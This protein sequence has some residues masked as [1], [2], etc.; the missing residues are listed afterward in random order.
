VPQKR[1]KAAG[2][3]KKKGKKGD[4]KPKV[5]LLDEARPEGGEGKNRVHPGDGS[6]VKAHS[7]TNA[8]GRRREEESTSPIFV[9]LHRESANRTQR[10]KKKALPPDI[11]ISAV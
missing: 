6:H 5:L 8:G 2:G 1:R 9:P 10:K 7:P 11:Q 4:T 3:Q